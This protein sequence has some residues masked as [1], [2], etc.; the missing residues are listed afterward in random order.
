MM[1][2]EYKKSY[3]GFVVFLISFLLSM[4]GGAIVTSM[5]IPDHT[6]RIVINLVCIGMALLTFIIYKTEK[7]YWYNGI[8][9]EDAE[10]A[11]SERRKAYAKSHMKLFGIYAACML[12][13]S[14]CMALLS[15]TQWVDFAVGA[16]GICVVAICT[17]KIKL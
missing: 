3:R 5:Y 10:K 9:F 13:F 15:V 4:F 2:N 12:V 14:I 6:S 11:G 17:V 7:I 16:I 1:G 8:E